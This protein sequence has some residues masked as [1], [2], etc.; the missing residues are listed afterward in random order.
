MN[1]SPTPSSP[2]TDRAVLTLALGPSIYRD[3]AVNLIRSIHRWHPAGT[4]PIMLAT[5]DPAPLP[6]EL[7]NVQLRVLKPQELGAGF[8]TKLHL[9]RLAPAQCTLFIDADCL[10][11]EPLDRLF[12]RLAGR[13][14]ATVG[15]AISAG[16]WFGDVAALCRQLNVPAIPKFNGGL[17]YLERG[18]KSSAVYQRARELAGRYDELGLVRLRGRP[19][20]ELLMASA[21]ALAGLAAVPDD[22][23]FISDPQACPGPMHVNVL[24]GRRE[25]TNPPPPSPRHQPWYP[26]ARVRPAIVHYLGHHTTTPLYRTEVLRLRAAARGWPVGLADLAGTVAGLPAHIIE[27]SKKILRPMFHQLFGRR[28]VRASAR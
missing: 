11:Y 23:T 9:D 2:A 18:E 5:D 14:V 24:R 27:W 8:E 21:M 13:P 19:N 4:L 10:V 12:G 1:P 22:G 17:Y 26:F 16:E 15:G 25:L 28:R 7:A 3:M 6:R 20:D